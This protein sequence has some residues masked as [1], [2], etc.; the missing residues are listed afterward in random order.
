MKW[1]VLSKD[2]EELFGSHRRS[3]D[4]L[5]LS[6]LGNSFPSSA[7]FLAGVLG[8]AATNPIDV[9]KSRMMNQ[10][11]AGTTTPTHVYSGA[12]DC[13]IMVCWMA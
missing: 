11:G 9:I 3:W 13:F 6:L 8:T 1:Y 12:L 5:A 7:S 10:R 4:I 2:L